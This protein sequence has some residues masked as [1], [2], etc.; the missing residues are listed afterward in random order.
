MDDVDLVRDGLTAALAGSGR[1]HAAA[2]R[3]CGACVEFLGVDGAALSI[4]YDGAISRSLGASDQL[5]R[6][7]DDLQ[8]TLGE[9]PCLQAAKSSA[10]VLVTDLDDPNLTLWPGFAEAALQRGVRA[11]FALPVS[12]AASTIGALDLYRRRPGELGDVALAGGLVAA[13]LA[14]LPLLD[15]MGID[16]EAA[17]TD[18]TSGAWQQLT[19]LTRVE[20]YQAAGMLIG[21]LNLSAAGALVRLRAYAY[22]NDLTASQVAFAIIEEGLLLGDDDEGRAHESEEGGRV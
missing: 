15:L 5:S 21:Q 6:E 12:A 19:E 11:V 9:G 20:V 4:I 13:E 8:F 22:I 10:P 1:G 2:E 17:V 18:E 7:L 14:A 3:L 16:L